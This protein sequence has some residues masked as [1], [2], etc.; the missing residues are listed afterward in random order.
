MRYFILAFL[1]TIV[2]GSLFGCATNQ[3]R[4][5]AREFGTMEYRPKWECGYEFSYSN[6]TPCW[7]KK[8]I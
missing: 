8:R 2:L 3:D 1:L 4:Y 5:F 7:R 6:P